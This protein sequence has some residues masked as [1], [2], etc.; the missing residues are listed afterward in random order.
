MK[1]FFDFIY[2]E[3]NAISSRDCKRLIN[4]F[5][6]SPYKEAGKQG[7]QE[8]DRSLK[9]STDLCFGPEDS[10]DRKITRVLNPFLKSLDNAVLNSYY[11]RFYEGLT[12]MEYWSMCPYFN[13]QRYYPGEGYFNW[14]SESSGK[15][16]S[17]R[18]LVWMIYLND[19]DKGGTEF[20]YQGLTTQAKEGSI[21]IWPADWTHIHRGQTE[22][23]DV[24]YIMTGWYTFGGEE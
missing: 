23:T 17:N 19:V 21:V 9:A 2:V 11:K 5:E 12:K 1:T 16:S 20:M 7:N 8:V 6:K 13:I 15:P 22:Q 18:K 14:H 4:F 24:K 3:E 10:S